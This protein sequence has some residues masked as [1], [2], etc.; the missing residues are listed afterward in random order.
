MSL[1]IGR[2]MADIIVG[3]GETSFRYKNMMEY[4]SPARLAQVSGDGK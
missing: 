3:E 1:G 2:R 4:L